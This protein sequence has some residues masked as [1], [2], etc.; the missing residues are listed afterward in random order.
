[1]PKRISFQLYSARNFKPWEPFLA[2]L[3]ACGYSEVEGYG[4]PDIYDAPEQF[5]DLL[6]RHNLTMPTGHVFPVM[7][8]ETDRKKL[9]YVARTLGMRAIYCPY[10]LP[11]EQPKSAAGWKAWG[12]RLAQTGE[13][14]RGE[15]IAFG[16]HNHDFEFVKLKDGSFPI[17]RIFE[18]GPLLDWECDIAWVAHARQNPVKW[19]KTYADRITAVHLKDNAPKG[20]NLDQHGQTDVGRGTIKWPE[21]FAAIKATRCL[22]HVVEHDNP[23]DAKSFAKRSYD[24]ISKN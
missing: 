13:W 22:H 3:A 11:E 7:A 12:R 21:V 2:H 4:D 19:L 1:M 20:E 15:G 16:W 6:T 23:K 17:E 18:G 10:I 14:L 5:R 8:L 9:L 24:F